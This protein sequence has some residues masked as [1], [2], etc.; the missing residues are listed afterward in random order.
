MVTARLED[1]VHV[2]TDG[3]G[4]VLGSC[5]GAPVLDSSRS[6]TY[7]ISTAHSLVLDA[8][9][10]RQ[11]VV[12]DRTGTCHDADVV[13]CVPDG[14]PDISLLYVDHILGRTVSC[15]SPP[16]NDTVVV[17]GALSGLDAR[18]GT[19]RGWHSGLESVAG[20]QMMDVV[21]NDLELLEQPDSTSRIRSLAYAGLRGMSGAPVCHVDPG[22]SR[23]YGMVVRRN[24]GG[25]ANRVYALPISAVRRHL[26][27][28]GFSL[29]VT[30]HV[31]NVSRPA[32]LLVIGLIKRLLD[33]PGGLHQLWDEASGLFYSG[34]PIDTAFRAAIRQ[35]NQFRLGGLQVAEVEFLLARLL[36]KRGDEQE[37]LAMLRDARSLAGR[38]ADSEY[39]HLAALI[40][41][42]TML[43]T[44]RGRRPASR[45]SVFE[46]YVGAY[47]QIPG[48]SDDERAYEVA[49]AIGSEALQLTSES[50]FIDGD[51]SARRQYSELLARHTGLLTDYPRLLRDK[52]EIVNIGMSTVDLMWG[53]D[54]RND[55]LDRSEQLADLS[56]RGRLAAIQ[57]ANG[58]FYAQMLLAEAIAARMSGR[59][60]RAFALFCL[61]G[62]ILASSQLRLSHEGIRSYVSYLNEHDSATAN[63]LRLAH[64]IDLPDVRAALAVTDLPTR[65]ERT[66]LEAALAWCR[67][68]DAGVRGV[69]EI[70]ELEVPLRDL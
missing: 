33:S 62:S 35:P 18:M 21:I 24:T 69:G 6:G 7:L 47:E 68:V 52:Q 30:R 46:H 15:V 1:A 63:L 5:F 14:K 4:L 54:R 51:V 12:V 2:V 65:A 25:I 53:D 26:V 3:E 37:G 58:I 45:R 57:R 67:S 42:R 13:V 39:R 11:V 20:E 31:D 9:R 29:Q 40:D 48:A 70:F 17:R 59:S 28:H 38:S 27:D 32:D 49:S 19:L 56:A 8:R 34:V 36:L 22:E 61:V 55:T 44:A 16:P 66:A 41:L 10:G 50:G 23:V 43:F 64:S 60:Y